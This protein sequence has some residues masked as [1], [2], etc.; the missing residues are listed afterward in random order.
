[1]ILY[2]SLRTCMKHWM[3]RA[4][5]ASVT[6]F[7]ISAV[8]ILSMIYPL[9]LG[10][11]ENLIIFKKKYCVKIVLETFKKRS[12]IRCCFGTDAFCY[13]PWLG[14]KISEKNNINKLTIPKANLIF[15]M[16]D[17]YQF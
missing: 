6:H 9:T 3:Y 10:Q 5:A 11:M 1:M 7:L 15:K 13:H 17:F 2:G 12:S 8:F 14:K 16:A 4:R